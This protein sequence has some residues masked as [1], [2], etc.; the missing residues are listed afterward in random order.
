MPRVR[1]EESFQKKRL[2]ILDIA[3]QCFVES[4]FHGAGMAKICKAAG[5]SP[6]ALY[7]YFPSKESMIEAIVEQER[8]DAALFLA[9]LAGA[10]NKA[11]G[12]AQLM[13]NA[14]L[15]LAKDRGYCQLSVEISAEAARSEVAAQLL[16]EA[17]ADI[18]DALVV[19]VE[20]GQAAGDI[21]GA[22]APTATAHLLMMMVD[23]FVGRLAVTTDWD[24]DAIARQTEAAVFKLLATPKA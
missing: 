24:V 21:D 20:K 18:I 15:F 6:G 1:D 23:G 9:D 14:V 17:D 16:A 11:K 22:L 13:A 3:A 7:R 10:E 12:L 8:A 2:Q 19:A 4:G 5:M